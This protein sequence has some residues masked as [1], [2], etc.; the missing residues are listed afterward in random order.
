MPNSSLRVLLRPLAVA[1]L[2]GIWHYTAQTWSVDQAD[3]YLDQINANLLLVAENPTIGIDY[4][5]VGHGVHRYQVGRHGVF[6]R[7]DSGQLIVIRVLHDSM[8]APRQFLA[9]DE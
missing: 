8:D 2:E 6:Y 4:S 5:H 9:S 7:V 3:V 1:D